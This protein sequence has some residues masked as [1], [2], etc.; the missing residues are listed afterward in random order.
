MEQTDKLNNACSIIACLHIILNHLDFI[1]IDD[2][3]TLADIAGRPKEEIAEVVATNEQM[4]TECQEQAEKNETQEAH[5]TNHHFVAYIVN[6]NQ[7]LIELDGQ[8]KE[9]PKI[10][11][12][13]CSREILLSCAAQ[14]IQKLL[15]A[16]KLNNTLS[17]ITLNYNSDNF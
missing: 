4:Q 16:G 17:L 5:G 12:E 13:N 15:A 9:G 6:D 7:Q 2:G 10:I 1:G 14:H 8:R 11:Q 3:S